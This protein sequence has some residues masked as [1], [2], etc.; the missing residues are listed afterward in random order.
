MSVMERVRRVTAE[1]SVRTSPVL[2][3]RQGMVRTVKRHAME[4]VGYDEMTRLVADE[5]VDHARSELRPAVEAVVNA[6]DMLELD[7]ATREEMVD[8][9]LDD[10]VGLGPLQPLIEDDS[11]TEIMVNGCHSSF[12]ERGG[13]LHPME[14]LFESDEQIRILIDRIIAP[15]GRRIDERSPLVNARLKNGYRVNAV[16][17]PI[18]IDGPALTIRKFSDR[19]TSLRELVELGSLPEWYACLL[20]CA[21]ALRQDLAVVGG[22]GSGKTT[23]L[24]ALSTEIPIGERIVTIEDS[25]ELKFARHPHVVRLEAREASIEGEGAVTIR[26]LVANSLRMRPD[27]IVVGEVRGGEAIDMLSAMQTGH[28]GSLTTLHAGSEEEAVVR[29]TLLARYG[30]NLPSELIEE[31][32]ALALD[33]IVMSERRPDGR[34]FVSSYSGVSRAAEGGVKL[35][36]Y[37]TFDRAS[38]SW[39]LEKEPPFIAAALDA[40]ALTEKEVEQWRQSCPAA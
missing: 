19:I 25:A 11:V 7:P 31:Q 38:A 12:F 26:D 10:I 20:S 32:I 4:R 28:D 36:R 24:N 30:I 13:T 6:Q 3:R 17:P 27:R 22:T 9:I 15:L 40:G 33:G 18:A 5:D 14:N 8:G 2:S 34:R 29:L 35:E 1:T 21:V 16:I 39:T 23:L 37:V